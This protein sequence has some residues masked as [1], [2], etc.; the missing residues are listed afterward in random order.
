M[1]VVTIK[2]LVKGTT[3]YIECTS[4]YEG[5]SGKKSGIFDEF[6]YPCGDNPPFAQFRTL[7]DLPNNTIPS[8]MGTSSKNSYSTLNYKF[9]LP[10]KDKIFLK[11]IIDEKTQTNIG[12]SYYSSDFYL[13]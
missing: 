3:Y 11:N 9:Y 12:T 7:K 4:K 5:L 2:N 13:I 8:G 10:E 1:K 6:V